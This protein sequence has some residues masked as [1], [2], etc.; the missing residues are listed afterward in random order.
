MEI[1]K[2]YKLEIEIQLF[3]PKANKLADI[4]IFNFS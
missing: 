3:S 2:K 4:S 1:I